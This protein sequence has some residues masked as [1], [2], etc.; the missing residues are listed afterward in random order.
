MAPVSGP[1]TGAT[2]SSDVPLVLAG[3]AGATADTSG[4]AVIRADTARTWGEPAG[5]PTTTSIV[6]VR[7]GGNC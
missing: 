6:E 7:F 2:E 3:C 1:W 4:R 5:A